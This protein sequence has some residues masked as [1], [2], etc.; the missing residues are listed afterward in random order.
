MEPS[1]CLTLPEPPTPPVFHAHAL[2]VLRSNAP[3]SSRESNAA[4]SYINELELQIAGVDEAIASLELRRAGLLQSAKIQKALLSPIRRLP[5]EILGEIFSLV[6]HAI[7]GGP[8]PVNHPPWIRQAPWSLIRVCRY[9]YA[10]ALATPLLWSMISVD[11]D[12]TG[13]Q[14][15]VSL[16][17]LWLQRS[18]NLPLFV[19]IVRE[20]R[21]R[22]VARKFGPV[23][24]VALS[25]SERWRTADFSL[26]FPLL[27]QITTIHGHLSSLTT[28]LFSLALNHSDEDFDEAFRD[29]FAV[30]PQ[31]R[32][33]HALCWEQYFATPPFSFPWHQL[34]RVSSSFTTN[35]EALCALQ[36]LPALIECKLVFGSSEILPVHRHNTILLPYLRSLTLQIDCDHEGTYTKGTSLLDF[37]ETPCLRSLTIDETADEEVVLGFIARSDCAA[38]L[39]SFHFYAGSID[40]GMML[41]VAKKMPRLTSLKIGDFYGTLFPFRRAS[42][43]EFLQA[44]SSQW[45]G[46]QEVFPDRSFRVQ[47]V[48]QRLRP[49]DMDRITPLL[50]AMQ[51]D[52]LIITV[53]AD[54]DLPDVFEGFLHY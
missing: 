18:K 26:D 30:A 46:G 42:L 38:S 28:L 1:F 37:L 52:G 32:S 49:E 2:D 16:T 10:V 11:L 53:S 47:I 35:T 7:F 4:T 9:W 5:P 33:L 44:F 43:P 36:K 3:L 51:K 48:D 15:G 39:T 17:E 34:T 54:L 20:A 23:L 29:V 25:S 31:L 13:E 21:A 40:H 14:S 41:Q 12:R 8:D 45:F 6:V 27:R 19:N 22:T 50:T 24:H